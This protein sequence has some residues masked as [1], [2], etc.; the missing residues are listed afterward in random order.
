MMTSRKTEDTPCRVVRV[1]GHFDV[2]LAADRH[3]AFEEVFEVGKQFLIIHIAV[4]VK[5]LFHFADAL[6]P[7]PGRIAPFASPA[8]DSNIFPEQVRLRRTV[9][10]ASTVEPSGRT[11]ASSVLVQS[12]TGM[13]L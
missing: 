4:S 12:K 2:V 1:N 5:E 11:R 9:C 3:D 10:R 13:K 6:R 8:I 7:Q